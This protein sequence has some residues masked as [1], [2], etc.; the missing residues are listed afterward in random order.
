MKSV[1]KTNEASL[2]ILHIYVFSK[3]MC[4][5]EIPSKIQVTVIYSNN[6]SN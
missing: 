6:N 1:C 3:K 2:G 5:K 4:G